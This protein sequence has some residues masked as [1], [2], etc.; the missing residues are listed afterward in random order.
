VTMCTNSF[1]IY[2]FHFQPTECI[3]VLCM[4]ART[5]NDFSFQDIKWSI[6]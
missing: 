5:S 1:I 2:K 6:L 4:T 3:C